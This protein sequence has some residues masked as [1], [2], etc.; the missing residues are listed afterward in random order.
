LTAFFRAGEPLA[1]SIQRMENEEGEHSL[2]AGEAIFSSEASAGEATDGSERAPSIL[3]ALAK[4]PGKVFVL[5]SGRRIPI[6]TLLEHLAETG[7]GGEWAAEECE[8]CFAEAIEPWATPSSAP[9]WERMRGPLWHV[10]APAAAAMPRKLIG[11]IIPD[12][13]VPSSGAPL[14]PLVTEVRLEGREAAAGLPA[15]PG[16]DALTG[17]IELSG[18]V[19]EGEYHPRMAETDP[20]I[21]ALT[22]PAGEGWKPRWWKLGSRPLWQYGWWR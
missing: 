15:A 11:L 18:L 20:A 14:E 16:D 9:C 3:A 13:R 6:D 10:W 21:L 22:P 19:V 2:P 5:P 17:E 7:S 1:V 12:Q 4:H 8:V